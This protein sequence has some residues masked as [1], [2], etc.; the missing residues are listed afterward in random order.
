MAHRVDH[1]VGST[2][3]FNAL[4]PSAFTQIE[5]VV[6]FRHANAVPP[7]PAHVNPACLPAP[8]RCEGRTRQPDNGWVISSKGKRPRSAGFG[9]AARQRVVGI[10]WPRASQI[11]ALQDEERERA[12]QDWDRAGSFAVEGPQGA[13]SA[14]EASGGNTATPDARRLRCMISSSLAS[15]DGPSQAARGGDRVLRPPARERVLPM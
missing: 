13:T 11:P 9:A 15:P 6:G 3:A 14:P 5:A 7:A 4:T 1:L 8:P 10:V 12:D 2:P